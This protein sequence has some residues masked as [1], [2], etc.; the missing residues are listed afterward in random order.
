MTEQLHRPV[1]SSSYHRQGN[2]KEEHGSRDAAELDGFGQKGAARQQEQI[3]DQRDKLR[4]NG[5]S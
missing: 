1:R 3:L 5:A 4:V 2:D